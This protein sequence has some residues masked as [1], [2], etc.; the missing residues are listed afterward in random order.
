MKNSLFIALTITTVYCVNAQFTDL[1]TTRYSGSNTSTDQINDMIVDHL[2]N[3][4]V[5]G[6][7]S[8]DFGD[9]ATTIKYDKDGNELWRDSFNDTLSN[10]TDEGNKILL[11]ES[12]N[13]YVIGYSYGFATHNQYLTIKYNNDGERQWVRL[14]NPPSSYGSSSKA[15]YADF[16]TLG[17]LFVGG[18]YYNIDSNSN[19]VFIIKYNPNGDSLTSL[20]YAG[21]ANG[22]D[23]I[24]GLKTSEDGYPHL[25]VETT[26]ASL[27]TDIFLVKLNADLGGFAWRK[28]IDGPANDNDVPLD[29]QFGDSN[30]V[31]VGGTMVNSSFNEDA[32][33]IKYSGANGDTLWTRIYNNDSNSNDRKVSIAVDASESIYVL[34]ESQVMFSNYTYFLRKYSK[35]GSL[36]WNKIFNNI[37]FS[38]GG[39][40]TSPQIAVDIEDNIF[41]AFKSDSSV[42]QGSDIHLE[43]IDGANG[44]S[45]WATDVNG[46]PNMMDPSDL[47]NVIKTDANGALYVGGYAQGFSATKD[48]LTMKF[49]VKPLINFNFE[50]NLDTVSFTDS[51]FFSSDYEWDFGDG[52]TSDETS[53]M[54][55]YLDTGTYQV[56]LTLSNTCEEKSICKT[57]IVDSITEVP[58]DTTSFGAYEKQ[59]IFI[60]PNPATDKLKVETSYNSGSLIIGTNIYGQEVFLKRFAGNTE[61]NIEAL[62][63]GIYTLTLT[64][65][66]SYLKSWSK[67]FIKR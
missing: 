28:T 52:G 36:I 23:R 51:S 12:M 61:I 26:N 57:V 19:D 15:L 3:V 33:L 44:N 16:D 55:I 39:P 53:P 42:N 66:D 13:V 40:P 58:D 24:H 41:V 18:D 10:S 63:K 9:D 1:W 8:E 50:I 5:T 49:C 35:E 21:N 4:Y 64:P 11:D 2:G 6:R 59:Q 34:G 20:N 60:S 54:H 38:G 37:H 30:N 32:I 14:F 31:Y 47:A 56:C 62:P 67:Q 22:A 27:N 48:Y 7:S 46:I 29:I 43:K 65:T 25:L 45:L 17:N